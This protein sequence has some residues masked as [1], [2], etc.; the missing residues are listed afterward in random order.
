MKETSLQI[1][2]RVTT[3]AIAAMKAN[4]TKIAC[5]T[6]YDYLTAQLVDQAGVDI[7]LVGDSLANV[8]QGQETTLPFTLD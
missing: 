2:K 1:V 3:K 4:N 7:V 5:I 8:F 6:A